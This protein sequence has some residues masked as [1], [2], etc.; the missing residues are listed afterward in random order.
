MT[1]G[2][3]RFRRGAGMDNTRGMALRVTAATPLRARRR[4][5]R[6][7]APRGTFI[8]TRS[9]WGPRSPAAPRVDLPLRDWR[10]CVPC[11]APSTVLTHGAN[12]APTLNDQNGS[13]EPYQGKRWIAAHAGGPLR[14]NRSRPP[15]P[16]QA[17]AVATPPPPRAPEGQAGQCDAAFVGWRPRVGSRH[18]NVWRATARCVT[19]R[20]PPRGRGESKALSEYTVSAGGRA[21]GPYPKATPIPFLRYILLRPPFSEGGLEPFCQSPLVLTPPDRPFAGR[22]IVPMIIMMGQARPLKVGSEVKM[23]GDRTWERGGGGTVGSPARSPWT[24]ESRRRRGPAGVAR[25]C[26]GAPPSPGR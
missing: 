21:T 10:S 5:L 22:E 18:R 19:G 26:S 7:A 13:G 14:G 3:V 20:G 15:R 12:E 16:P 25:S 8:W 23:A 11:Y 9:R 4:R 24:R 1:T 17:T 6:R 2:G